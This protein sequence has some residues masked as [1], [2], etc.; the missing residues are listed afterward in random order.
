[1]EFVKLGHIID[2]FKLDGT[3]KVV[4]STDFASLRYKKGNTIYLQK[5]N[6]E[7]LPLT[8][9]KYHN[10]GKLDFVK[11]KEINVKED[12]ELYI[13]YEILFNKDEADIPEGYYR[14]DDLMGLKVFNENN[15]EMGI[16]IEVKEFPAQVTL[17]VKSIKD[18]E[19]YVPFVPFFIKDVDLKNQKIVIHEIG[20]ML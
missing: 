12:A 13:G 16:I 9:E 10:N 8:I 5:N 1:M 14:Y 4:S 6:S 3:F 19:F 7:P 17:K 18:N 15:K 20:G 2:S 11:T